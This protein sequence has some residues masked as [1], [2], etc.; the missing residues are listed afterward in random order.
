MWWCD[1]GAERAVAAEEV[2][3]DSDAIAVVGVAV[4]AVTDAAAAYSAWPEHIASC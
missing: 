4:V 3:A 1:H 2:R